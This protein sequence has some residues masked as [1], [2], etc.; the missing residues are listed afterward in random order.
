[1]MAAIAPFDGL[2]K[3][4]PGATRRIQLLRSGDMQ[5]TDYRAVFAD[6]TADPRYLANLDWGDRRII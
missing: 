2:R 5:V 6:V 3:L 4:A 1:M